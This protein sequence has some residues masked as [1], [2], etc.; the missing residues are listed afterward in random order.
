MQDVG[1]GV[2]PVGAAGQQHR[3]GRILDTGVFAPQQVWGGLAAGV[4]QPVAIGGAEIL[5]PTMR[6]SASWSA[7]TGRTAQLH[8]RGVEFGLL[9]VR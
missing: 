5:V 9:R 8:L 6:A 2:L 1:D 7:P 3:V 4:Q